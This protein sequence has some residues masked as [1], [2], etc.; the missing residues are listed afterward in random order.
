VK[1]EVDS[2]TL[3][4]NGVRLGSQ[5]PTFVSWAELDRILGALP[6]AANRHLGWFS[7][8]GPPSKCELARGEAGDIVRALKDASF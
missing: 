4:E 3:T 1:I 8:M 6:K 5:L 2:V 7:I